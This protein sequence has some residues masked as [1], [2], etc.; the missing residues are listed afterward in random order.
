[1]D[2]TFDFGLL[3]TQK[4]PR[5]AQ[6]K[7]GR[8]GTIAK[9]GCGLIALYNIERAADPETRFDPYYDARNTIKTNLFGLLGTR[10]SAIRKKLESKGFQVYDIDRRQP[11]SAQPYDAVIVLYWYWFGAHYV[12]GFADGNGG[13]TMYNYYS[14][15]YALPLDAFLKTLREHKN[16]VVRVWGVYFPPKAE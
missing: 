3:N 4:D 15:P 9:N 5:F 14:S 10:M 11:E 1:M 7:Y 8:F 12:A 2:Q 6:R 16:R 13:Y